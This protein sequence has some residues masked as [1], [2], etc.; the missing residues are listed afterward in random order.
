MEVSWIKNDEEYYEAYIDKLL[1][2]VMECLRDDESRRFSFSELFYFKKWYEK[3]FDMVKE[4]VD[5]VIR[6]GRLELL[7]GGWMS[8]D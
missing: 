5:Y 2:S 8:E 6:E 7:N 4:F 3:Q 1:Y